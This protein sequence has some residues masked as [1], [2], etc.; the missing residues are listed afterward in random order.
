MRGFL[1]HSVCVSGKDTF[2]DPPVLFLCVRV[3]GGRWLKLGCMIDAAQ[4]LELLWPAGPLS[5]WD[6]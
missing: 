2:T 3:W 5:R 6:P 1:S 4:P